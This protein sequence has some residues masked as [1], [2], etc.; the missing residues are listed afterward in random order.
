MVRITISNLQCVFFF[1]C[2]AQVWSALHFRRKVKSAGVAFKKGVPLFRNQSIQDDN[3]TLG[4][5]ID[6]LMVADYS[7][8][9][10][11]LRIVRGDEYSAL[12]ATNDYLY[13]IFEQVRSIYD[14]NRLFENV[15]VTLNL[16]STMTIIREE[17]CPLLSY[18]NQSILD[19]LDNGTHSLYLRMN[20]LD[21][22]NYVQKWVAEYSQW[23]PAHNHIILLTKNGNAGCLLRSKSRERRLRR[24]SQRRHRKPGELLVRQNQC[25][26]AFGS[27]YSVCPRKEYASKDPCQRLWCKNRRL[28]RSSP[29]ETKVYLPLLDGTKCG[30]DKWCLGGICVTNDKDKEDCADLNPSMCRKLPHEKLQEFCQSKQFRLLCCVTC[31]QTTH[32]A[33]S[34]KS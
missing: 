17:D 21:A 25:K 10:N 19:N 9:K 28:R 1:L 11:F 7:I 6:I 26:I 22:V 27:H 13:A 18:L 12:S 3:S 31:L 34:H 20:A 29:C 33:N 15:P 16:A 8:Y 5:Q 24:T 4:Y 32:Y 23:I 2:I 14:G 30:P